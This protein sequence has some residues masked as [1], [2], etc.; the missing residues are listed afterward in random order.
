LHRAF[1]LRETGI[2]VHQHRAPAF[3]QRTRLVALV[4]QFGD[5]RLGRGDLTLEAQKFGSDGT[6][7]G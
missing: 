2:Q 4:L 6:V 1:Q 7:V 5:L 3:D